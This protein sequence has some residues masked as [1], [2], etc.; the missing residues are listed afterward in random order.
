MCSFLLFFY[1]QARIRRL[2]A[3]A[4]C[5]PRGEREKMLLPLLDLRDKEK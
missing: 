2:A 5:G 4:A 3:G 1:A